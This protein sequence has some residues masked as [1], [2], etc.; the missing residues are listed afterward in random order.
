MDFKGT[1]TE[2]LIEAR[3][4]LQDTNCRY[5]KYAILKELSRTRIDKTPL[6]RDHLRYARD[7]FVSGNVFKHRIPKAKK[8]L[9][10]YHTDDTPDIFL[11]RH[12]MIPL[13]HRGTNRRI[14][15]VTLCSRCHAYFHPWIKTTFSE[16]MNDMY[17]NHSRKEAAKV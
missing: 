3:K 7:K 13:K 9:L 14:N 8:C 1:L 2:V 16:V 15:V 5:S 10:C 4:M 12:H 11:V 6:P 17:E